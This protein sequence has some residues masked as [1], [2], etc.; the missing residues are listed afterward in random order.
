MPRFRLTQF[1]GLR[2]G[3]FPAQDRNTASTASPQRAGCGAVAEVS[4]GPDAEAVEV[5]GALVS[6]AVRHALGYRFVAMDQ[7]VL[8]MTG[9]IWPT[10]DDLHHAVAQRRRV[11]L[12]ATGRRSPRP[13]AALALADGSTLMDRVRLAL[14]SF[15]W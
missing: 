14:N 9:G 1:M 2:H 3:C 8:D 12:R 10:L 4:V 5:R 15:D 11:F 13:G 7:S 6:L